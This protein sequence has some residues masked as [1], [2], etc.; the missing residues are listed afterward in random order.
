MLPGPDD[1]WIADGR[2]RYAAELLLHLSGPAEP[3]ITAKPP[4]VTAL[5]SGTTATAAG[6]AP[7]G[8]GTF[9]VRS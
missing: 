3:G 8:S 2:G 5:R 1:L 7:P 4:D 6:V 9:R